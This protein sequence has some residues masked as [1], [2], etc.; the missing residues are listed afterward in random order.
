MGYKKDDEAAAD[1]VKAKNELESYAY[2]MKQTVEEKEVADKISDE[3]KTAIKNKADEVISWLDSAQAASKE[4]YEDKKKE[5]ESICTPIIT[6]M[7]QQSGGIPGGPGAG[8]PPPSGPPPSSGA[9]GP[10]IEE[11]D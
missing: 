10:T 7:Y 11:V 1:R 4:E 9:G 5:I 8:A 3:D 2:Q 6:K